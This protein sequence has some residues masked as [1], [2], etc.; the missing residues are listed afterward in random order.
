M[1]WTDR[2][3]SAGDSPAL[4]RAGTPFLARLVR[5]KWGILAT[6]LLLAILLASAAPEKH[7]S[8]Y[9]TAA[10]YSLP[11]VQREG[12][13]YVGLLEVLEPLG[14]VSARAD[15]QRWRLRFYRIEGDFQ[16]GRGRARIH[17]YDVDLTAKFLL[18][19]GRGLVPVSALTL[20][21]PRILGGPVTFHEDASRLFIGSVA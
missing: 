14:K 18:E 7:L 16:A 13:D 21:L 9:S 10:N 17:G 8:V 4:S 11:L 1:P 15:G 6:I 5:E 12:R 19:N 2:D 20:L 3:R